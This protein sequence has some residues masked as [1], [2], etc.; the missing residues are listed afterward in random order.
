MQIQRALE[1]RIKDPNGCLP[2]VWDLATPAARLTP[3]N[4]LPLPQI[5]RARFLTEGEN[6]QKS[7]SR[8]K[9]IFLCKFFSL[10]N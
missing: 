9:N 8:T 6:N 4:L 5:N 10:P 1:M 2:E 7:N 3:F